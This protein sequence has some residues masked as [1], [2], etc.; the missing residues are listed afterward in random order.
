[1]RHAMRARPPSPGLYCALDRSLTNLPAWASGLGIA[2]LGLIEFL[3]YTLSWQHKRVVLPEHWCTP[4][5]N[6]KCC[7]GKIKF[8]IV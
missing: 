6:S 3:V 7:C 5:R 2:G 1:M 4:R 8:I